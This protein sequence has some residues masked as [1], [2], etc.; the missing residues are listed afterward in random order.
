MNKHEQI[1]QAIAA[2]PIVLKNE[3]EGA[4]VKC[5]PNQKFLVKFP[6]EE[7]YEAKPESEIVTNAI[8][9]GIFASEEQFETL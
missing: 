6:G 3:Q 8:L 9:E 2:G 4:L 7:P 1:F 5:F